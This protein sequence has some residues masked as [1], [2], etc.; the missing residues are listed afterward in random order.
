[1]TAQ[2][3]QLKSLEKMRVG[4]RIVFTNGCFDLLHAGHISYLKEA[5]ALGDLL[6]VGLNSDSSVR[7]LKGPSRPLQNQDDRAMILGALRMVDFVYIFDE[8]TPV[9]LIRAVKPDVLVKGGD[10]PAEKIVGGDFVR[11]YGGEVKTLQFVEGRSTS[12]LVEKMKSKP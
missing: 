4:K 12:S 5:R 8:E 11:S 6:V 9:E 1:M 2:Q 7:K 10:W 3:W